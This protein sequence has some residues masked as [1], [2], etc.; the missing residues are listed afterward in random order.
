MT[1]A[2]KLIG[3]RVVLLV[4][5][6]FVNVALMNNASAGPMSSYDSL[7]NFD[8]ILTLPDGGTFSNPNTGFTT[9]THTGDGIYSSSLGAATGPPAEL[10]IDLHA[11]GSGTGSSEI[12]GF[13]SLDINPPIATPYEI[14]VTLVTDT[15][16]TSTSF[17]LPGT[18]SA[19]ASGEFL[20]PGATQL[21]NCPAG[22]NICYDA[23]GTVTATL[24]GDVSGAAFT[25]SAP[26]PAT[27]TLLGLGLAG[28]G[29]SRRR[30]R[31]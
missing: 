5:A 4:G 15:Q 27:L 18:A 10:S 14:D 6:A 9:N 30:K 19:S 25:P 7:D 13:A 26:E 3:R 16:T 17:T 1:T 20:I 2:H 21:Q 22:V 11:F 29:F 28:L 24:S 12:A 8:F 23:V 31:S